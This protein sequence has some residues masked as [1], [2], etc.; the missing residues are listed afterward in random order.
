MAA[1]VGRVV[2]VVCGVLAVVGGAMLTLMVVLYFGADDYVPELNEIGGWGI[3]AGMCGLA[4]HVAGVVR[5]H[6][7]LRVVA[8]VGAAVAGIVAATV[9]ATVVSL[10][11]DR[12]GERGTLEDGA[13][14]FLWLLAGAYFVWRAATGRWPARRKAEHANSA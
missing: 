10:A 9:V 1:V 3:I 8:G 4:I 12:G 7:V 5:A 11:G 13:N 6:V 14:G 2:L